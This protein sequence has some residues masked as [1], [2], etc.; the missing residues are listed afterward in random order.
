MRTDDPERQLG[1]AL[2]RVPSGIFILTV[3][4]GGRETGMLASWIQQCSFKPPRVSL[5]VQP[6]REC[7]KL[8]TPDAHLIVNIL[9]SSQTDMGSGA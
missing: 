4:Q 8:I 7:A 1:A 9:E 5:A 6:G 3:A 2:G